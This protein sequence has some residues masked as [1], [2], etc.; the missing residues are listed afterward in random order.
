MSFLKQNSS[1]SLKSLPEKYER[2]VQKIN[3]LK[4]ERTELQ[5]QVELQEAEILKWVSSVWKSLH[6][7]MFLYANILYGKKWVIVL[8]A[9][10]LT[11]RNGTKLQQSAG[12]GQVTTGLQMLFY[13]VLLPLMMIKNKMIHFCGCLHNPWQDQD[14][15]IKRKWTVNKIRWIQKRQEKQVVA[16]VGVNKLSWSSSFASCLQYGI[17]FILA[18]CAKQ[19]KRQWEIADRNPGA[20]DEKDSGGP[21]SWKQ[22]ITNIHVRARSTREGTKQSEACLF[23]SLKHH[24]FKSFVGNNY[25]V[26]K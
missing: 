4:K 2:A 1:Q 26:M 19:Q 16:W 6:Q 25:V 11:E 14:T 10:F 22:S 12:P 8:Q 9:E 13:Y 23:R 18:G 17:Y 24:G 7:H 20:Q 21:E 3:L 5:D 15:K